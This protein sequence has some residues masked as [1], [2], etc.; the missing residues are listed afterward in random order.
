MPELPEVETIVRA[1][2]RAP[3][4]EH[5]AGNRPGPSLLGR[6]ISAAALLW[7]GTLAWQDAQT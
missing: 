2:R 5:I 4:D 7:V 6:R 1:L 3:G